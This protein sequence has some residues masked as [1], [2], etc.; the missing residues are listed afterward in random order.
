MICSDS[1][2]FLNQCKLVSLPF[3]VR[4]GVGVLEDCSI[5]LE[6]CVR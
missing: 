3:S 4:I 6:G 5:K 1:H 2:V